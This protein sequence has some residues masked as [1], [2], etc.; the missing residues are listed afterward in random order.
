M[1]KYKHFSKVKETLKDLSKWKACTRKRT[2]ETAEHAEH[3]GQTVYQC[4]YCGKFHRATLFFPGME[5]INNTAPA[6]V[7]NNKEL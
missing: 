6:N 2:Y 3:K 4:R 7:L 1:N 5:R